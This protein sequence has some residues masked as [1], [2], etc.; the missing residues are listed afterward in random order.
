MRNGIQNLLY[1]VE[2]GLAEIYANCDRFII[3]PSTIRKYVLDCS[4]RSG[5]GVILV[6]EDISLSN[7]VFSGS[8]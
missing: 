7:W 5:K 2:D 1:P 4:I 3:E 6:A 8:W